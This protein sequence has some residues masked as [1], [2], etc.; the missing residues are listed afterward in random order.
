MK[1]DKGGKTINRP[2]LNSIRACANA[3][4]QSNHL[5]DFLSK[6]TNIHNGGNHLRCRTA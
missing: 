3:N 4:L 1:G 2:Q 6:P 5:K